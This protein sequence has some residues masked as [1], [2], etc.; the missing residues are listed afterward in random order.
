MYVQAAPQGGK[1][2]TD[3]LKLIQH[4][5]NTYENT[6][7]PKATDVDIKKCDVPLDKVELSEHEIFLL[8]SLL[9]SEKNFI[10]V[11]ELLCSDPN[12]TCMTDES[13]DCMSDDEENAH[14]YDLR[15]RF[16]SLFYSNP[17]LISQFKSI[18]DSACPNCKSLLEFTDNCEL[19]EI[20]YLPLEYY[21]HCT[22]CFFFVA[23][24]HPLPR[25]I[26]KDL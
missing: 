22:N 25:H 19:A 15:N 1:T 23:L 14:F 26:K 20:T 16:S 2:V 3:L 9:A 12:V 11:Q 24:T 6:P 4:Y 18:Q 5:K 21:I 8:L 10:K 13:G 7:I 17:L